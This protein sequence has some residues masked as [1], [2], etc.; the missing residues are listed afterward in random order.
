MTRLD[1]DAAMKLRMA[2]ISYKADQGGMSCKELSK[3]AELTGAAQTL[4]RFLHGESETFAQHEKLRSF[5]DRNGYSSAKAEYESINGFFQS[6]ISDIVAKGL[7]SISGS[8][9]TYQWSSTRPGKALIS[10]VQIDYTEGDMFA[11]VHEQQI[12]DDNAEDFDGCCF[13]SGNKVVF[14][15]KECNQK[16]P[17]FMMCKYRPNMKITDSLSGIILKSGSTKSFH[18]SGVF[19]K[20][21]EDQVA[22]GLL[23]YSDLI[24]EAKSQLS[25][26]LTPFNLAAS[27][28]L[29]AS[30]KDK[31]E[32]ILESFYVKT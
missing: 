14:I 17:K 25:E 6:Q 8:Y 12:A 18:L 20:K 31:W 26:P 1:R 30:V 7:A 32:S 19:M 29:Y 11:H 21:T 28:V 23:F 2:A 5:L 16:R 24:P 10:L 3:K 4:P 15:L 13:F 27:Q 9:S 22:P